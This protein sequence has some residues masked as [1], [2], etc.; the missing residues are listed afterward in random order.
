MFK[1]YFTFAELIHTDQKMDNVPTTLEQVNNLLCLGFILQDIREEFGY[2]IKVNSAFRTKQVN[3]AVG[4]VDNSYHLRGRAADIRPVRQAGV[5]FNQNLSKL[6]SIVKQ[7]EDVLTE[8]II[9]P[10]FIHIAI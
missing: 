8:L 6:V 2:P 1:P 3:D 9:Y 10:T 7:Y 4:G 5:D